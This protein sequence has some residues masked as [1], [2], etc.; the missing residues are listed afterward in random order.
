MNQIA[1]VPVTVLISRL[2][3]IKTPIRSLNDR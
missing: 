2:L 1:S 3:S